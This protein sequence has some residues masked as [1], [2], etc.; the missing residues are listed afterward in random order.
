[1]PIL[2]TPSLLLRPFDEAD[3]D[4]YA[5]I[6]ADPEVMR[7]L[8]DPRFLGEPLDR[9]DAWRSMATFLGHERLR[10]WSNNAVTETATGKLLGR[11]GLW[12]PEGWPG[13]EVGWVSGPLRLGSRLCNRGR[14]RL[15]R[16]GLRGP[17]GRRADLGHPPR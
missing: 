9:A 1:M 2:R 12:R 15:A 5:A 17:R 8:G 13:L 7:F 3:L 6:V 4:A 10:G 11:C 16:L 14:D